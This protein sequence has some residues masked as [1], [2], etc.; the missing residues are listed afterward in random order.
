MS[1]GETTEAFAKILIQSPDLA[2]AAL[3]SYLHGKYEVTFK[4]IV[5]IRSDEQEVHLYMMPPNL[6][7]KGIAVL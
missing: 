7:E 3:R 1:N 6:A 5:P 4:K 2:I